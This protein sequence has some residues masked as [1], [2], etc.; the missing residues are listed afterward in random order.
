MVLSRRG[1]HPRRRHFLGQGVVRRGLLD[2]TGQDV[3]MGAADVQ[4]PAGGPRCDQ[5]IEV[6]D[7]P[8]TSSPPPAD[9]IT[10]SPLMYASNCNPLS[11]SLKLR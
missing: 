2:S 5:S 8:H 1:Q 6:P 11:P 9:P 3:R 7:A 10:R 4:H